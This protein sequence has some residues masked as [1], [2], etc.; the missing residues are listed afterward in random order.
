M[1]KISYL[2][3]SSLL[4]SATVYTAIVLLGSS[5][6]LELLRALRIVLVPGLLCLLFFALLGL[7]VYMFIKGKNMGK[8]KKHVRFR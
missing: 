6:H 2:L 7:S 3:I 1:N 8:P 4:L 5:D